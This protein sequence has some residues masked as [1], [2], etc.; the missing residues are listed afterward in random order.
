MSFISYAQNFEDVML[1]RALSGI[2]K[3]FYIDVGANDPEDDSVTNAFYDRGWRGINIEPEK[4]FFDRL[5]EQR[6]RDINLDIAVSD[7]PEDIEIYFFETRGWSTGNKEVA[8]AHKAEG[9]EYTVEKIRTKSLDTICHE[10][11]VK[12]VH[13]LKID[14]EG[15]EKSVLQSFSFDD[16]RPW[17]VVIEATRPNTNIDISSDWEWILLEQDYH[18]AY[19]DGINKF[20]LSKEH[21]DLMHAFRAPPNIMDD[22]I[23]VSQYIAEERVS[24]YEDKLD[25]YS[26]QIELLKK[27]KQELLQSLSWRLT[28][29]LRYMNRHLKGLEKTK[30]KK[31][32]LL[33]LSQIYFYDDGTGIQRVIHNIRQEIPSIL[34]DDYILMPI[35][36]TKERGYHYTA[37]FGIQNNMIAEVDEQPVKIS[38]GDI[39]LGIDLGAHLFPM[40][41]DILIDYRNDGVSINFVIY[42]IIPLNYPH[43]TTHGIALHFKHWIEGLVRC[44]DRLI[45][46]SSS[47]ANDVDKY[48]KSNYKDSKLPQI[49]F[50]H[51]GANFQKNRQ[52]ASMRKNVS[53]MLQ[54]L[55][56]KETYLMVGTLE[57][58]KAHSQVLNA[59]DLLWKEGNDISL[60]VVGKAGWDT[61]KLMKRIRNHPLLNKQLYWLQDANDA[62]LTESYKSSTAFI[63]ASYTEGFGLPI[64]EASHYG[65]PIIARD[66]PVFRE[67]AQEYAFYF[68]NDNDADTIIDALKNWQKLYRS[69]T[70]PRPEKIIQHTWRESAGDLLQQLK[71]NT[72]K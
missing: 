63:M 15:A 36:A 68:R 29:P 23:R 11:D 1:W 59:F 3:G 70:Y 46:I 20:Y 47:V 28:Y 72:R 45:C 57:P 44:A 65:V 50:F 64:I 18:F 34:P 6:D 21:L 39:F 48:L 37:K 62:E 60:L 53:E 55:S 2:E 10:Y 9:R 30:T 43:Y 52:T 49:S 17:I 19:F 24:S 8:E 61:E 7:R 69:G 14:V 66:I 38:K 26:R 12:E 51:L 22:F 67:A 58:R 5:Q 41:K 13:F 27:E 56:K 40:I 31:Q 4:R 35:Y 42:D 71:I 32:L 54:R 33:D 25:R 16:I